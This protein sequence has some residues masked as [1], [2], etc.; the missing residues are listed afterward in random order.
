MRYITWLLDDNA[1]PYRNASVK[2]WI[3]K[4]NIQWLE[5]PY[6]PDL[7]PWL[8][9]AVYNMQPRPIKSL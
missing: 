4:K 9:I 6:S 1:R 8:L 3:K 2:A 5:P 7:S